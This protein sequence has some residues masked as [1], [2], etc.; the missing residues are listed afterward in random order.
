MYQVWFNGRSSKECRLLGSRPDMACPG[1]V[2]ESK[3]VPGRDGELLIRKDNLKDMEIPVEFSFLCGPQE[4]QQRFREA[5]AW[6]MSGGTELA[7]EDDT[8][9]YYRV[10]KV[11]IGDAER[12]AKRAGV[13]TASFLVEGAQYY[14]QGKKA[15]DYA[16]LPYNPGITA[17]PIYLLKGE[18]LCTI[19]VNGKSAV[20][21]VGQNATVDTHRMLCFREDGAVNNTIMQGYYEDIYLKPGRN[22]VSISA[23]FSM[24]VI[25]NWRC[26]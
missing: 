21:N 20:V 11:E 17:H 13:F 2:Y 22:E 3:S 14:R 7:F 18:G 5:K 25:P 23:G 15:V 12:Q 4:W 19:T 9:M 8:E 10:K 6:L 1:Y 26:I 16:E 24:D